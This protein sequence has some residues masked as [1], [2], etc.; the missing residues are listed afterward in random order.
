M[1]T[2]D[3][4]VLAR[5]K[6]SALHVGKKR[7]RVPDPVAVAEARRELTAAHVERAIRKALDAAPPLTP[8]QR[9]NLAALLMGVADR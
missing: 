7:G 2:T 5:N 8:E 6:L 4:V 1:P 3:P 9:G